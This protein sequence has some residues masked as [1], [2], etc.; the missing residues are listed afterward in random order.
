MPRGE[1]PAK[2]IA[3]EDKFPGYSG[4]ASLDKSQQLID[5]KLVTGGANCA[6]TIAE[7]EMGS[8]QKMFISLLAFGS[9]TMA[10]AARG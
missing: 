2:K 4:G 8:L 6:L 9:M 3:P 10:S 1:L 7:Y 5:N